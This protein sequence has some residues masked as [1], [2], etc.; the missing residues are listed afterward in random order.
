[1]THKI[2]LDEIEI[3]VEGQIDELQIKDKKISIKV[4]PQSY[5]YYV[6]PYYTHWT[7]PQP[8]PY[9]QITCGTSS[10]GSTSWQGQLNA[11]GLDYAS[12]F[13]QCNNNLATYSDGHLLTN[14]LNDGHTN[15][16]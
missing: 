6:Y 15:T 5:P 4:K 3:E 1:M 16:V 7:I 13:G 9:Y 12:S 8:Q 14:T 2:K 10:L 11:Q